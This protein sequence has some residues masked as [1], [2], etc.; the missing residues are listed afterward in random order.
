MLLN[1]V[2]VLNE[3]THPE[4]A[5]AGAGTGTGKR[6]RLGFLGVGW[7]GAGRM[8][9]AVEC[10]A[11]EVAAVADPMAA[12][13]A[14]AAR[15]APGAAICEDMDALF[16]QEPDGIVIA[17][18]SALR[19]DQAMA[20]LSAGFPVFCQKP[21]GRNAPETHAVI[22]AARRADRRL[23][24][25]M[26][27]RHLA[28][29]R[30]IREVIEGGDIGDIFAVELVFHNAYAPDKDWCCNAAESGGGCVIDL[31]IHLV[32]LMLGLLDYPEVIAVTSR[33]MRKGRPLWPGRNESAVE[34]YASARMDLSTGAVATLACSWGLQAG[35]EAVIGATF[36]GTGG[37]LRLSNINGSY[38]DFGAYRFRGAE[39]EI[40]LGPDDPKD[41]WGPRALAAWADGLNRKSPFDPSVTAAVRVADVL[42][43]IYQ[44]R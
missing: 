26:C 13:A 7:I 42:D 20:A 38:Y 41:D 11:C 34:D 15:K 30:R 35:R 36:Y 4:A 43:R 33:L 10:G 29:T 44:Q 9:A 24:V 32:D 21:L 17:T 25:D 16:A 27:Y 2:T 14:A 1:T 39:T 22:E 12:A 8:T 5:V 3:K 18:P 31:G 28:A 37:G 6:P 19:A 40:L 23:G